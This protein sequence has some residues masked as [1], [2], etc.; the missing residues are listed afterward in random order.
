MFY[1]NYKEHVFYKSL[2]KATKDKRGSMAIEMMIGMITFIIVLCFLV[3]LLMLGWKFAV[4]SQTNSYVTRTAGLQGGIMASAP[5]GFPGGDTAYIS[6][7]EMRA[8][9]EKSFSGAKIDASKYSVIV[10]GADLSKGGST[11]EVDYRE[12]IDTSIQVKYEWELISNFIP[13][14]LGQTLSSKRSAVSEFKYRYD[15][16]VGE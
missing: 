16:W 12:P 6:S 15:E 14:K 11:G 9:I 1:L 5:N 3:D 4:I 13:G 2:K 7:S 10:N 8:D